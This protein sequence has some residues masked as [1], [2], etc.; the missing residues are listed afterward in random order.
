MVLSGLTEPKF[1]IG[2]GLVHE[3]PIMWGWGRSN[4]YTTSPSWPERMSI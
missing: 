1:Q 4:M 2:G 3:A